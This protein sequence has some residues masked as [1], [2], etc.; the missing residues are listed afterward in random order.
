MSRRDREDFS[1]TK[2]GRPICRCPIEIL[3]LANRGAGLRLS[4]I[5][6]LARAGG[7]DVKRQSIEKQE[8]RAL[9]KIREGLGITLDDLV[10]ERPKAVKRRRVMA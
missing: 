2:T 10:P 3:D 1:E 7:S 8:R 6:I 9:E 4:E 5:V